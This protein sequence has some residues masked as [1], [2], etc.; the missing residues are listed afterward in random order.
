LQVDVVRPDE[1]STDALVRWTELQVQHPHLD[2][3]FLS[4]EFALAV[5]KARG[6]ARVAVLSESDGAIGF[7]PYEETSAGRGVALAKG[8]SDVQ[9]LVAAPTEELDLGRI[10]RECGLRQIRFDHLLASQ[11][12]WFT[13]LPSRFRQEWSS[14]LDLR[15]GFDDYVRTKEETTTLFQAARRNRRKLG[16]QHGPVRLC[17]DE[18]DHGLLERLLRW[19]SSQYRRTGR[20]DRF[21]DP[22]TRALVHDLLDIRTN[23]FSG[24]LTALY[25]GDS[26][27]SAH[28]GLRTGT[29]VA[30]WFPVYDPAYGAYSPG[31][32]LCV[33]M[34]RAMPPRGLV[35]LD[36]GEG[37]E[38]YKARLAN[39]AIGLLNGSVS[40][41]RPLQAISTARRWPVE[42]A[43]SVVLGSPRLRAYS[44]AALVKVGRVREHLHSP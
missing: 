25:A 16:S 43:M 20:R 1:L 21:A 31:L 27:V 33:E 7:L 22:A 15:G 10:M 40:A 32:Q 3:P 12:D 42:K 14:A 17:F 30:W 4:P 11:G 28:L 5:G 9:G 37:D 23:R 6:R 29:T 2:S 19:K 26:V 41:S 39:T 8:L 24:L 44:R 35:L 13:S 36:L 18:P 34:A 38:P